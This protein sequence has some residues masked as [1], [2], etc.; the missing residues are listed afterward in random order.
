MNLWLFSSG[1]GDE[2]ESM[3]E[4]LVS[5]I[6]TT[7]P[8]YTFIP[9]HNIDADDY[10]DEFIERFSAYDYAHFRI[11]DPEAGFTRQE[12][13][14]ALQSDMIYL[15]GGNT[16]HFLKYLRETGLINDLR[17]YAQ[18]GGLLAGHSAG[19]ILMTPHIRMAAIPDFDRDDNDVGLED[20]SATRLVKFEFF[21][22]YED[23]EAYSQELLKASM[24]TNW[25]IYA[26]A[27]GCGLHVN[28]KG[29][30]SYGDVWV[31]YRGEK[32]KICAF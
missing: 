32:F 14:L 11:L 6:A 28:K 19:A 18:T 30:R 29:L 4:D 5:D 16:F 27:D 3:D 20:L 2:N 1:D 24:Y 8:S 7:K 17:Y 23:E 26:A 13:N 12:L 31:F 22:H 10:Y 25:P 9:A 21:P 15:S